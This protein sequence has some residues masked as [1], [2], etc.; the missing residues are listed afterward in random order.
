MISSMV[1]LTV[2]MPNRHVTPKT[3]RNSHRESREDFVQSERLWRLVSS[4]V[5]AA[6]GPVR[7]PVGRSLFQRRP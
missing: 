7:Q 4:V 6:H 2:A 3:K 1:P 5:A